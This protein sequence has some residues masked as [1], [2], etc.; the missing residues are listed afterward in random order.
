MSY[1]PQDLHSL[2]GNG[3]GM[4]RTEASRNSIG[5]SRGSEQTAGKI[6]EQRE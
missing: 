2:H 4:P 5:L 3:D 1:L 6:G